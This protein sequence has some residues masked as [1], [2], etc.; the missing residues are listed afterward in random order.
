MP[1]I[2][3]RR[4]ETALRYTHSTLRRVARYLIATHDTAPALLLRLVMTAAAFARGIGA[5]TVA[6]GVT[7]AA[8]VGVV[9]ALLN[10]LRCTHLDSTAGMLNS[11]TLLILRLAAEKITSIAAWG[12]W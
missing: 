7:A 6:L 10:G 2:Q 9:V 11:R 1:Q 12:G 5:Q 8:A 4:G 3:K